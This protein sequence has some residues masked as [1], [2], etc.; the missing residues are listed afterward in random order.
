MT[1]ARPAGI[2]ERMLED[3]GR[4]D[5]GDLP[6]PPRLGR[7]LRLPQAGARACCSRRSATWTSTSRAR[8]SSATTSATARR[9]EAAGCPFAMVSEERPLLDAVRELLETARGGAAMRVLITGHEGYIGSVMAPDF[10]ERGYDVVGLDTG[11]FADCTL[12]PG[13]SG[14]PDGPEGHP[15]SRCRA[16]STASTP[17]STWRRSPT[18]RSA[19]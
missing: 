12:V 19:T 7:G 14:G 8:R 11:Y 6:L 9:R 13:R 10:L 18:T 3:V 4:R 16:T 17:S 5:R 2:H 1:E 15:R